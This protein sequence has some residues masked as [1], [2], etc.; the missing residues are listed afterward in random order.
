MTKSYADLLREARAQI[1]EVTPGRG[2][3]APPSAARAVVDVREASEWEQGHIPGAAHVSKSYLEQQIEAA[4]PDRDAPVVLYCAG[5]VRSLFAAQT[6]RGDGLHG[7]RLDDAAA[8]RPGSRQGL[9]RGRRPSSSPPSRSSATAATCSSPRSAPRARRSCSARR[10]CSSAPAAS[11]R[12][13]R[14]TSP[15]PAWARSASST[16]TS[17]TSPT[18]SARSSTRPTG[19]ARRR[20]SRRAATINALNPDVKVVAH[21]EMLVADNV[22]RIIA[23]YDVILDGTDTFETRYTLNDAAVAAGHPG[24]PRLGLPVRGPADGVHARTRGRAT[25][26]ST[27]R[28]RRPSSRPAARSPASWASCPGSWA[29]SRRTRRSRSC[30]ASATRSPAGCSS[31]TPSTPTFTELQLRRDP[32]C[33]A[34]SDA[35]VAARAAGRPLAVDASATTCRSPAMTGRR[36]PRRRAHEHRPHPARAAGERRRRRSRSRSTATTVG[37][38]LDAL[39]AQYPGAARPAA[40]RGRR[41][42]TASSTSTSTARTSATSQE[43]AT[44]VAPARRGRAPAGDGRAADRWPSRGGSTTPDDDHAHAHEALVPHGGRYARHPR[45]HR[46]HAAGRDPADVARTRTSASTPSSRCSTRPARSRTASPSTS[47]RTSSAAA[48]SARDSI[49]LEPTS[50]NTGIALA[51]IGAPQG[52]PGRARHA[53]QRDRR[54]APAGW[55]CSAPRSSTRPGALGSNGAIALAKHLVAKDARFVMPYQYG[56]PANPLRPL[57]DDR[58]GDPRRLPGDRRLRGRP[59]HRRHADGRRRATCASTSPASGST[60]PSRCPA[61]TSRACARSTRGSCP[62]SSTRRCSTAKFLVSQRGGHRGAARAR[63]PRGHLRR[64]VVRGGARRGGRAWPQ[65]MDARHDRRA[66]RRRRLEVPLGRHVHDA[67]STRWRTTS[68]AASTGGDAAHPGPRPPR[69][70]PRS[71]RRSSP[72]PA[73]STRTR[74]AG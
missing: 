29:C 11:A 33:P 15:R 44:P 68:R 54:A 13:P 70:P 27:R 72:T 18:S 6:L 48:G 40:D 10:C 2:R 3:R 42:S 64:A 46:P 53:R 50:G 56:N 39:V 22:E 57:R 49:I 66:A 63:R 69:C 71:A 25:A 30:S 21:E 4:V 26:A 52:L 35:A 36:R 43:L 32:D 12:R 60:P 23:G 17:S 65:R 61:R 31:S 7:R 16:S 38:V 28:R 20:S 59:G 8:S 37:E 73:P 41:R 47:S 24:R 1:R 55:R 19:S 5:G 9:R 51:M 34:C 14:S 74:P 45:R 58:P 67:T 62:R